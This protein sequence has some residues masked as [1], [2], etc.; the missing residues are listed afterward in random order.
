MSELTAIVAVWDDYVKFLPDCLEGI[1]AQEV[2]TR[3]IVVDN[4]SA[5]PVA[6]LGP[7]VDVIRTRGR[8]TAGAARNAGLADITTPYVVFVDA[9]DVVLPGTWR[10]LLGRLEGDPRLVAAAAQLWWVDALTGERR[11]APSPRPH[12]Y[13]HLNR[14]TRCLALY[15]ALRMAL[16]ASNVTIFRSAAVLDAGGFGD[17]NLA[18]DW[19]LSAA[20]ALRGPIEQYERPG[21]DVFLHRGSLFNRSFTL[22]ETRASMRGVRRRLSADPSTPTWLRL[23]L[24]PIS[25]FHE[26]KAI[27]NTAALT[28]TR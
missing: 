26:L 2:A 14:R 3:I 25:I 23:L 4:A 13:R 28:F 9:D 27:A 18:E 22:A 19:Q 24:G 5:T 20:V 11:R 15:T 16:P 8:V 7:D 1:R 17:A 6:R 12:V 10:F 21:A